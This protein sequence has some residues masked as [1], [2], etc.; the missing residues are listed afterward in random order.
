MERGKSQIWYTYKLTTLIPLP[1]Y[2]TNFLIFHSHCT[3]NTPSLTNRT[4]HPML[5]AIVDHLNIMTSASSSHHTHT[6]LALL[7]LRCYLL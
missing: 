5:N 3:H 7:I 6:R 2:I 1:K 4:H